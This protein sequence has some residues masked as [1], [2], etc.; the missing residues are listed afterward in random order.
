MY[1]DSFNTRFRN[2]EPH[3]R[4]R[5]LL[6]SLQR[7]MENKLLDMKLKKKITGS[8]IKKQTK[9]AGIPTTTINNDLGRSYHA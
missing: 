5:K 9:V 2:L 8:E 1:P 4:S 7:G 6:K 3:K